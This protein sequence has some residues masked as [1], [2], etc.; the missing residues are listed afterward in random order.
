[1]HINPLKQRGTWIIIQLLMVFYFHYDISME[2]IIDRALSSAMPLHGPR[3][4]L[5]TILNIPRP[6]SRSAQVASPCLRCVCVRSH[7]LF[8]HVVLLL[9]C[10]FV[11]RANPID[12]ARRLILDPTFCLPDCGCADRHPPTPCRRANRLHTNPANLARRPS[13]FQLLLRRHR[14]RSIAHRSPHRSPSSRTH[15]RR[16]SIPRMPIREDWLQRG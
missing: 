2:S 5:E 7:V 13:S 15:D 10:Y 4:F 14:V 11:A 3:L 9:L 16:T 12:C 8:A 6:H 1:M